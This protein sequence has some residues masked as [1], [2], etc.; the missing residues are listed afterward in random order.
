MPSEKFTPFHAR[1]IPDLS[2][3]VAIVTGGL[4]STLSLWHS[5]QSLALMLN[6]TGNS[7][8]GYEITLQFA[9]HHARV[10]I[11]GRSPSR[12]KNAIEQM[13]ASNAEPLDLHM[14]DM[15]LQNLATDKQA[16]EAFMTQES[17]LDLLIN[18]AGVKTLK[19]LSTALNTI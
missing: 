17:R 9:L 8:I 4:F 5:H 6:H 11:A 16:A 1:D 3:Y 19:L 18:N 15:D 2:G 14:L 10:Y 13:K 7:G 12:I